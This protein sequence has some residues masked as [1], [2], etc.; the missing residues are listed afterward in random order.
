MSAEAPTNIWRSG[1]AA[2][3]LGFMLSG[4]AAASPGNTGTLAIS[5][6]AAQ[7]P[8]AGY[9]LS[10]DELELNCKQLTGRM[11]I[12]ILEIRDHNERMHASGFSNFMQSVTTA[13]G[14]DAGEAKDK[15]YARDMAML[16]AYNRQLAAKGCKSYDLAEELK[17]KDVMVTPT[18]NVPNAA[19]KAP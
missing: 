13:L 12:R 19:S 9:I 1:A 10:A 11:Q 14:D 5:P 8:Q 3:A 7:G 18:A 2:L 15:A 4:C 17:P 6:A 16:E